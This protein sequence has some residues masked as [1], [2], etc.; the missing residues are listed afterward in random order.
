MDADLSDCTPRDPRE[1]AQ[2]RFKDAVLA[3]LAELDAGDCETD[4]EA[5]SARIA[6]SPAFPELEAALRASQEL[7]YH[8][9]PEVIQLHRVIGGYIDRFSSLIA[10]MRQAI[11]TYFATPEEVYPLRVGPLL[12]ILFA[13]MTAKPI[14]DAFFA[15]STR[16]ADLDECEVAV[17]NALRR[18]VENQM[19]FRNDLVHADWSIG[20]EDADTAQSLPNT[21]RKIKTRSGVPTMGSLDV[22]TNDI[23][24]QINELQRTYDLVR[25]FGRACRDRQLRKGRVSDV[26]EVRPASPS[27]GVVVRERSNRISGHE[28]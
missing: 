26:L 20:W 12:D 2:A 23:I 3:L 1:A 21:A 11:S 28:A 7:G 22:S 4:T 10:Y 5:L 6:S 25:I 17:R 18:S 19:N 13:P 24:R 8:N 14:A 27:G 9:K 16:V 15:T